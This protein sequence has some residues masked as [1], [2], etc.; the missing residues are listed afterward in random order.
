MQYRFVTSHYKSLIKLS[1]FDASDL[2][3]WHTEFE[4]FQAQAF[5]DM[6]LGGSNG[7]TLFSGTY[8]II[9]LAEGFSRI[10]LI[11]AGGPYLL[12]KILLSD[13]QFE[14]LASTIQMHVI[15][16]EEETRPKD[17]LPPL[18]DTLNSGWTPEKEKECFGDG[19]LSGPEDSDDDIADADWW[20]HGK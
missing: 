20:K 18:D 4:R 12:F 7:R 8:R 10:V 15:A 5:V 17:V 1:L 11:D 13:G 2:I 3:I 14:D 9:V 19:E 6:L 16:S